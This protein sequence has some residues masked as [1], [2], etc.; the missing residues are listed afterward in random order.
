MQVMR[1]GSES[2]I[3]RAAGVLAGTRRELYRI[4]ADGDTEGDGGS[5]TDTG[6]DAGTVDTDR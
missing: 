1:T 6:A 5:D 3:A 2:Q 4:L